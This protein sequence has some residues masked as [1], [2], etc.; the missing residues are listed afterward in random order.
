[1]SR[2]VLLLVLFFGAFYV[3]VRLPV[4]ELDAWLSVEQQ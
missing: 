4:A 1:M 2:R 3:G